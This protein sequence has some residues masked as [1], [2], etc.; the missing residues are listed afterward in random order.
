MSC[1]GKSLFKAVG[2]FASTNLQDQAQDVAN[3]VLAGMND[4]LFLEGR[5][6]KDPLGHLVILPDR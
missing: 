1:S 4:F 2:S 6:G 5:G 3:H